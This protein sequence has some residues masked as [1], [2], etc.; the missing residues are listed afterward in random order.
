MP[1]VINF[2]ANLN[3]AGNELQNAAMQNLAVAPSNPK[4]GQHYYNTADNLEYVW[5]GTKWV[6][7]MS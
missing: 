4:V 2:G 1:A 3:L 5:D 6:S 7:I